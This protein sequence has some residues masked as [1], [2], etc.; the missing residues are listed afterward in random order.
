MDEKIINYL[1]VRHLRDPRCEG[2]HHIRIRS[3]Y[4]LAKKE[5]EN[6]SEKERKRIM[7]KIKN[8][9]QTNRT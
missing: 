4:I 1:M 7:K 5:F 6:I 9:K 3:A 8:E 2:N